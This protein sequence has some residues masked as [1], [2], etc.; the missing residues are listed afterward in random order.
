VL[1]RVQADFLMRATGTRI[2]NI[3]SRGAGEHELYITYTFAFVYPELEEGS[4]EA[5]ARV[6]Q[7]TGMGA[8]VVPGG[9]AEMREL[10]QKGEI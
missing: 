5:H 8:K 7:M 2:Q 3:I 10:A 6:A 4:P 1:I 9:V